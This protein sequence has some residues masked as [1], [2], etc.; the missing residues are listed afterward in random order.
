M[1]PATRRQRPPGSSCVSFT[2]CVRVQGR[3][4]Q[5]GMGARTSGDDDSADG[6]PLRRHLASGGPAGRDVP[7]HARPLP[8]QQL[9]R[10]PGAL[11]AHHSP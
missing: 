8:H 9:V 11:H 10:A 2:F 6:A 3:L 1:Q 7:Q 4:V 5:P